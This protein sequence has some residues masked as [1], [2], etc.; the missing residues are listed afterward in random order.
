MISS[1]WIARAPRDAAELG[2][3]RQQNEVGGAHAVHSG[4]ERHGNAAA[5]LGWLPQA[6]HDVDEPQHRAQNAEGRR[7]ARCRFEHLGGRLRVLT[8]SVA[9]D[10]QYLPGDFRI[11][12]IDG[13]TQGDFQKGIGRAIDFGLERNQPFAS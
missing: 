9:L 4:D 10:F 8:P 2:R 1:R 13:E 5:Q 3:Q 12:P 7:V 11:R 6:L